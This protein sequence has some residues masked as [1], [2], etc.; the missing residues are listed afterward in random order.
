MNI[1]LCATEIMAMSTWPGFAVPLAWQIRSPVRLLWIPN[2]LPFRL[3]KHH[4]GY[5]PLFSSQMDKFRRPWTKDNKLG[6]RVAHGLNS[7]FRM[8]NP[9][10]PSFLNWLQKCQFWVQCSLSQLASCPPTKQ[11][12]SGYMRLDQQIQDAKVHY[13]T[14][15]GHIFTDI[16]PKQ[17]AWPWFHESTC[18]Y[19]YLRRVGHLV[20]VK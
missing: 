17:D 9:S 19:M 14:T 4:V 13:S 20:G 16:F 10:L 1:P 6:G 3:L 8:P 2:V 11:H 7:Q 18:T 15:I 12:A 5:W